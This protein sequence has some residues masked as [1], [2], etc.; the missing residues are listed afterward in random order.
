MSQIILINLL[1]FWAY[2]DVKGHKALIRFINTS[3]EVSLV[4]CTASQVAITPVIH[5]SQNKSPI[6]QAV[7]FC[8]NKK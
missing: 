1:L 3:S 7:C 8:K 6:Q 2:T 5:L 4:F